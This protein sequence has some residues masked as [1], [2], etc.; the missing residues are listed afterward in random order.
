[1]LIKLESGCYISRSAIV[2]I[3]GDTAYLDGDHEMILNDQE[4]QTLS[5]GLAEMED[6]E[7]TLWVN[8]SK[9]S[10][11]EPGE[12]DGKGYYH[13]LLSIPGCSTFVDSIAPLMS[14]MA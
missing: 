12:A 3:Q 5:D 2:Y 13:L 1:M 7:G 11:I 4:V 6:E 8:P 9:V 10:G 14:L